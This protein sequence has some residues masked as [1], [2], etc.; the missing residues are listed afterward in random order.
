[1][2]TEYVL[3]PTLKPFLYGV[4]CRILDSTNS[5]A[6]PK[7][8][9][10]P[11]SGWIQPIVIEPLLALADPGP[12]LAVL[13]DVLGPAPLMPELQAA[14]S[15]LPPMAPP[16]MTAALA[17]NIPRR[18]RSGRVRSVGRA[19]LSVICDRSPL[20]TRGSPIIHHLNGIRRP[21][22]V[23]LPQILAVVARG[24]LCVRSANSRPY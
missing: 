9:S 6:A 15:P 5:S 1:M 17:R 19:I 14:S 8:A 4:V 20:M 7:P 11:V 23:I 10:G 21:Q 22:I 24:R 13:L 3:P 16:P 18:V 12:L 2:V